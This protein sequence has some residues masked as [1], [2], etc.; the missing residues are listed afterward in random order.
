[1]KIGIVSLGCAKNLVDSEFLI[2]LFSDPYFKYEKDY[3]KCDAIIINTCGFIESAK[4]E[5]L[6]AIFDYAKLKKD[7]LKYLIVTG[8][9]S[10]R[11]Y[12]DLK[13]QLDEVDLFI[14]IKDYPIANKLLSNLF[15]HRIKNKFGY[16]RKFINMNHSAYLRISDGCSNRCA[17]CAIPLIRGDNKSVPLDKLYKEAYDLY[18]KGVKELNIV[19]QDTTNYGLDLYKKL[20][21][22]KLLKKLDKINFKWIRILYMYPDE[23]NDE[24]LDT[25]KNSKHIIPYFDIPIQYG[26]DRLLKLMNRRGSVSS[27][28]K[29][30]NK[31]RNKFENPIIRTTIIV[32][33]PGEDQK[34][35][36]D[37]LDFIKEIK[38][39]SMGAFIYSREE[40]TRAYNFKNRV[41][42][43][44]ALN[45]H[46][47]L[48]LTQKRIV[49][50]LMNKKIGHKYEIIVDRYDSEEHINYCRTFESA[51]DDVDY[52]VLIPGKKLII[53]N[54]YNA[55]IT[56]YID[57]DFIGKIIK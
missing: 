13:N 53:G 56:H 31:I 11:Y 14:R 16:N 15:N 29:I 26:N 32:G 34:S 43:S 47:K 49:D 27:I 12:E 4:E 28:K 48:M 50:D 37:T 23:I 39:D 6:K 24:L 52:Y 22:S 45:R 9:L 20:S 46:N 51:P 33:F 42:K 40:D 19:A 30:I 44:T 25:I 1:M 10:Q 5:S 2:G 41:K 57:Y 54:L 17:Y 36:K 18:K 8:C 38:F 7:K 21:L 35:F 3:K 55:I